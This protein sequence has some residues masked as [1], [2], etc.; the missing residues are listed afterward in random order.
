[1]TLNTSV[2]S[3]DCSELQNYS[4]LL[5]EHR[6]DPKGGIAPDRSSPHPP[7]N[8]LLAPL[9]PPPSLLSQGAESPSL[10]DPFD[11]TLRASRAGIRERSCLPSVFLRAAEWLALESL[12]L[13]AQ[14]R[15]GTTCV[16]GS[17]PSWSLCGTAGGSSCGREDA[18]EGAALGFQPADHG[19]RRAAAAGVPGVERKQREG[20]LLFAWFMILRCSLRWA[21]ATFKC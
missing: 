12:F 4:F 6:W 16:K 13:G 1:V 17:L 7:S 10:A 3:S 21:M 18:G 5:S 15:N 11:P 9:S 2:S 19:G 20:F 14:E 8:P